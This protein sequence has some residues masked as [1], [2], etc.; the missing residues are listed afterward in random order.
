MV[1]A[2]ISGRSH[3]SVLPL[4]WDQLDCHLKNFKISLLLIFY[5]RLDWNGT[6]IRSIEFF[7]PFEEQRILSIKPSLTGAP[8]KFSWLNTPLRSYITNTKYN[9]ALSTRVAYLEKSQ[10]DSMFEWRKT[11][12]NLKIF[13]NVTLF[14]W[15]ALQ[16]A[17]PAGEAL[18]AWQLNME[19]KIQKMHSS[20]IYRSSIFPLPF[21]KHVLT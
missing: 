8:N 13:P 18:R 5:Y 4:N 2:S 16:V 12:C 7:F 11:V 10:V 9:V 19:G 20:W 1:K 21:A 15:K 3:S 6:G 17:I 14:V